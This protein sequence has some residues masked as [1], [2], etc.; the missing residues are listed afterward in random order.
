MRKKRGET[1]DGNR[2]QRRGRERE[3]DR[4]EAEKTRAF[5]GYSKMHLV[6]GCR[7]EESIMAQSSFLHF[8]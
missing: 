3:K 7:N 8:V 4:E 6:N 2:V 5:F 1:R